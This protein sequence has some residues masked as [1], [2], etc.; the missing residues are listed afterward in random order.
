MTEF[1]EE[2]FKNKHKIWGDKVAPAAMVARD[3]FLKN[4]VSTVLIPGI[5]Y[6]RNVA[7]FLDA[8]M[9]VTGIEISEKAIDIAKKD[10]TV[11]Y[12]IHHGS[13]T[14]MPFDNKIYDGVFCYAVIHLLEE[15]E[16]QKLIAD[17]YRQLTSGGVM[18]FVAV[19]VE[20]PS[21]GK[22]EKIGDNRF[23]QHGGVKIFFYD[24]VAVRKEFS[25]HGL[26][27]I[28]TITERNGSNEMPFLMAVSVKE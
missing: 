7:P 20:A 4:N 3:I 21:Y 19:S 6:G 27:E 16:R 18:V 22:G 15:K 25:D 28:T 14:D 1:W 10:M 8:G 13:V 17:C 5:G 26:I 2:N 9:E 12:V 23:L 11:N 24:E